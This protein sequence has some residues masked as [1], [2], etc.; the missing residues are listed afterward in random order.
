MSFHRFGSCTLDGYVARRFLYVFF[1]DLLVFSG[2]Y[3]LVDSLGQI[4]SF[5][6]HSSG[7][8]SFFS[9]A[10]EYY[11]Y[12]LPSLW[13]RILGPVITLAS[14]M[15]AATW[16]QRD[17]ELVPVLA[18]GRSLQRFLAPMLLLSALIAGG[19]FALQEVWI[20]SQRHAIRA[21]QSLGSQKSVVR[22]AIYSD[23]LRNLLAIAREFR[24][25]E[26]TIQGLL[27]YSLQSRSGR[28]FVINAA[29]AAWREGEGGGDWILS[30]ASFQE[31]RDGE[32][33]TRPAPAPPGPPAASQEGPAAAKRARSEP[34]VLREVFPVI[35]LK[36]LL[37]SRLGPSTTIE[38]GPQDLE[39]ETQND[40]VST[41]AELRRKVESAPERA[42]WLVK[43]YS[44]FVDPLNHLVLILLGVPIILWRQSRNLF[45][46]ALIV[47]AIAAVYFAFQTT[48]VY[49]GNRGSLQPALAAWLGPIVFGAL[50]LT[51]YCDMRT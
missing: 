19:S 22:H 29:G 6:R 16:T 49:L 1:M 23:P 12:E 46:S 20:P 24:P 15:F 2:V 26:Q 18:T 11:F 17:N 4:E 3:V 40:M 10:A 43:Y 47:L 9:V 8:F 38:M 30:E 44:R 45:L 37:R 28:D 48:C 21:A 32:L 31:Y 39:D 34:R 25:F 27:I 7:L 14:A 33:V 35:A 42:R 5:R 50:G 41:L 36:E 13:C 51:L